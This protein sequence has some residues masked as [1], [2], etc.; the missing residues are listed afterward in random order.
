MIG[1]DIQVKVLSFDGRKVQLGIKAPKNIAVHR[2]EI[3]D[4]IKT[5]MNRVKK[6][7]KR[8]EKILIGRK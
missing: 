7:F 8:S 3:Y 2:Q 1:D 4:R 5:M 6:V